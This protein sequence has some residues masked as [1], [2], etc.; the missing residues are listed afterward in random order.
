MSVRVALLERT[1]RGGLLHSLR[2]VGAT[3]DESWKPAGL[4][5]D[6][7]QSPEHYA[8]GAAWIKERLV[9]PRTRDSLEL[10]VLDPTGG[11]CSWMNVSHSDL[12]KLAIQAR[13]SGVP[14]D[15]EGATPSISPV[16]F[17]ASSSTDS[18]VQ[19]LGFEQTTAVADAKP[20]RR[21][22]AGKKA[23]QAADAHNGSRRLAV[24]ALTDVPARVMLDALDHEGIR[25]AGVASFWHALAMAWSPGAGAGA[26]RVAADPLTQTPSATDTA[27]V[28]LVEDTGRLSWCW[29]ERDRLLCAGVMRC[30]VVRNADQSADAES[31]VALGK[32]DIARLASEW[33]SWSVQ[34]QASPTRIVCVLPKNLAVPSASPPDAPANTIGLS[35]GEF[36]EALASTW[37][38][39]L[40]DM[41]VHEDPLGATLRRLV[42]FL[43]STPA[44]PTPDSRTALLDLAARPGRQHRT[45]YLWTAGALVALAVAAG[46]VGW[47]FRSQ[48][49]DARQTVRGWGDAWRPTVEQLFPAA[50]APRPTFTS[51]MELEDEV[52]RRQEAVTGPDKVAKARPILPEFESISLVV[53]APGIKLQEI[54]LDS[55]ER[56][57]RVVVIAPTTAEAEAVL[58]GLKRVGG[59]MLTD[60]NFTVQP[61]GTGDERRVTLTAK[62]PARERSPGK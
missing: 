19:P 56:P 1:A 13:S 32:D 60:W 38:G 5:A 10:L 15:L 21:Q 26:Q 50:L 49:E 57:Q 29:C 16:E 44:S 28:I 39:A 45:M 6:A 51:L 9:G 46:V 18:S 24:L 47:R 59:S 36:G 34:T 42:S 58:E 43:E 61:E 2:L 41:V 17:F 27:A 53:G 23:D 14:D 31:L 48:A 35:A 54:S 22:I 40:L 4:R 25:T 62:W 12:A 30:P 20:S 37:R 52:K 7:D 8:Q 3:A 33:L 55:T 11:V